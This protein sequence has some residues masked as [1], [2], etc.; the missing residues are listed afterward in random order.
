MKRKG[1][2]AGRNGHTGL[3]NHSY[4]TASNTRCLN[5]QGWGKPDNHNPFLEV[6]FGSCNKGPQNG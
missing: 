2:Q 4:N 6:A 5:E 1:P 3:A